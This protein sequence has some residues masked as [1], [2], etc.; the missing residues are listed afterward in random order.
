MVWVM[1]RVR[2]RLIIR[3]SG[4]SWETLQITSEGLYIYIGAFIIYSADN[5][6]FDPFLNMCNA[7]PSFVFYF[8]ES[9]NATSDLMAEAMESII[10]KLSEPTLLVKAS[11]DEKAV[12]NVQLEW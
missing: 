11:V 12:E 7:L 10:K 6:S 9:S 4:P 8:S 2:Q 3:S 5:E 1:V